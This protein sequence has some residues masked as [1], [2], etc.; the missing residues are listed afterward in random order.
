[1]SYL[2]YLLRK[3]RVIKMLS[4]SRAKKRIY[5]RA[6]KEKRKKKHTHKMFGNREF[7]F[8]LE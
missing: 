6:R 2:T 5:E 4:L 7:W 3:I 1:M 8:S